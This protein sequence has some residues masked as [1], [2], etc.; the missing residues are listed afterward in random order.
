MKHLFDIIKQQIKQWFIKYCL[1]CEEKQSVYY[2]FHGY[3]DVPLT[4][5]AKELY[6]TCKVYDELDNL[7][8][9]NLFNSLLH[10]K[11]EKLKTANSKSIR[12][13]SYT[14]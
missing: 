2:Y 12:I 5:K 3:D 1:A 8:L 4:S 11:I 7:Q 13:Q 14:L 10:Q 9:A 6:P